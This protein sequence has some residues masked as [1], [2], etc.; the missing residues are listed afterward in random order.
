MNDASMP[1]PQLHLWCAYPDDLIDPE[2]AESCLQILSTEELARWERLRHDTHKREYLAT[3]ALSRNALSHSYAIAP[4]DWRF[5]ANDGGKPV[6]DPAIGL[7]FNLSNS[8]ALAVC[9]ISTEDAEVGVDIEPVERASSVIEIA[10]RMFSEV[11][12]A[13]LASLSKEAQLERCLH[14][15]TLKE[16]YSKALGVGLNMPFREFSFLFDGDGHIDLEASPPVIHQS[17]GWRFSLID[18]A[19]HAIAIFVE[20]DI[21]PELYIHEARPPC[22]EP[23]QA[24]TRIARWNP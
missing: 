17:D 11:E 19:G 15:W 18:Y 22:A 14:L 5:R 16:A 4:R 1:A 3:H 7:R 24:L 6:I 13:Q 12:L 21:D 10:P 8:T 20:S 2:A 9:L 23:R